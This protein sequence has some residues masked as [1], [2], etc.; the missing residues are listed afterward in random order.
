M[1]QWVAVIHKERVVTG[2]L[3]PARN[4]RH[5]AWKRADLS[6]RLDPAIKHRADDALVDKLI[7][8]LQAVSRNQLRHAR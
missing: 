3:G 2:Y 7:T 5:D 8:H 6:G 1:R 4:A